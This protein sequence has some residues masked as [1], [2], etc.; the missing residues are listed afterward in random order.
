MRVKIKKEKV[1]LTK[2]EQLLK[3][4]QDH[5]KGLFE[6]AQTASKPELENHLIRL[7]AQLDVVKAGFESPSIKERLEQIKAA[8]K[9]LKEQK[10]EIEGPIKDGI[11]ELTIKIQFI[12][13]A[14]RQKM[15][16]VVMEVDKANAAQENQ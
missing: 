7:N 16:P 6:I 1:K 14:M 4:I 3:H 12:L 9:E 13:Y 15:H 5:Y 2:E 8:E 11:K 10:K